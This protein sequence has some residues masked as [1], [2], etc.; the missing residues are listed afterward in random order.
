[1]EIKK[2]LKT[3]RN[4]YFFNAITPILIWCE[5]MVLMYRDASE[6]NKYEMYMLGI[7]LVIIVLTMLLIHTITNHSFWKKINNL[8]EDEI[9][10]FKGKNLKVDR[11]L[12]NENFI[13]EYGMFRKRVIRMDEIEKAELSSYQTDANIRYMGKTTITTSVIVLKRKEKKQISIKAPVNLFGNEVQDMINAINDAVEGKC[14]E[15]KIK[16][17]YEIFLCEIPFYGILSL[18]IIPVMKGLVLLY[19]YIRDLFIVNQN[20]IKTVLF[21]VAYEARMEIIILIIMCLFLGAM[22]YWKYCM[23]GLDFETG[24][25]Y[26]VLICLG[27]IVMSLKFLLPWDY[28]TYKDGFQIDYY[29]YKNGNYEEINTSLILTKTDGYGWDKRM[30]GIIERYDINIVEYYSEELKQDFYIIDD[31]VKL[32]KDTT[33]QVEYLANSKI[34]VDIQE[35]E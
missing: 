9:N 7:G 32:D 25:H 19:P 6:K 34:I 4:I 13:L 18:C 2:Q 1:M 29:N 24:K 27:L 10:T 11:Y 31:D 26:F 5:F 21:C 33:Y 17:F 28:S 22:F 30:Q 12:I 3:K 14:I 23:I 35:M 8:T 20:K 15:K 16:E